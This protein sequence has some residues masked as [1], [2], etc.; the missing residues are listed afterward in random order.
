MSVQGNSR[1]GERQKLVEDSGGRALSKGFWQAAPA[2]QAISA[3]RPRYSDQPHSEIA[4]E[5]NGI[6]VKFD[7]EDVSYVYLATV[8]HRGTA[9]GAWLDSGTPHRSDVSLDVCCALGCR[10]HSAGVADKNGAQ[11]NCVCNAGLRQ[12]S[13]SSQPSSFILFAVQ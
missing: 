9:E 7:H 12:P 4:N 2:I 10:D 6:G 13:L 3:V 8:S 1:S 5:A 11:P